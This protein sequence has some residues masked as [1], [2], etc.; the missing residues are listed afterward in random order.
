MKT[1]RYIFM[2]IAVTV[3]SFFITSCEPD[4]PDITD[5]SERSKFLG[6]WTCVESSQLT[7][8]VRVI[9]SPDQQNEV[10]L[11]NFHNLDN[12]TENEKAIG[13][14]AGYSVTITEQSMCSGDYTVKGNGLMS[15]NKQS[16]SFQYTSLTGGIT[17]T[18][19]ATYTKQ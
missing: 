11:I 3:S 8:T 19:S 15:S 16:I 5:Y 6:Y 4:D 7:Y 18:I 13:I 12:G 9:E 17:D 2:V 10:F 1:H 14:I